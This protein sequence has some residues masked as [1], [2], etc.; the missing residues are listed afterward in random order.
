VFDEPNRISRLRQLAEDDSG[1]VLL[2]IAPDHFDPELGY[3][4]PGKERR[5]GIHSV[6][7]FIEKPDAGLA[8]ALHAQRAVWN[9]FII[10][11]RGQDLLDLYAERFPDVVLAMTRAIRSNDGRNDWALSNLYEALPEID[12]SRHVIADATQRLRLLPVPSC[13]WSDLGTPARVA[14]CLAR[15]SPAS[16]R[17]KSSAKSSVIGRPIAFLKLA[18][19]RLQLA[20]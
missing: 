4:V 9:S 17:A 2:G 18:D 15:I 3:I 11:A 8:A 5:T 20:G 13:G 10:A 19:A 16:E 1:I 12:F 7:V 6:R 14:Q